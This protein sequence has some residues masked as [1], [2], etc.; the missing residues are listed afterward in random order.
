M[1]HHIDKS[2]LKFVKF[3]FYEFNKLNLKLDFKLDL[4]PQS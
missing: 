1:A 3:S 4:K 2:F